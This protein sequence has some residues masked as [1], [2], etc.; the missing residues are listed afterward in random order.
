MNDENKS[1]VDCPVCYAIALL[2]IVVLA[3]CA[4]IGVAYFIWRFTQ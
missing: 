4:V 3:T 2:F 1:P